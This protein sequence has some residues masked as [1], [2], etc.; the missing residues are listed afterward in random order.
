MIRAIPAGGPRDVTN[1]ATTVAFAP[2][3]G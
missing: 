1:M 2:W 3:S